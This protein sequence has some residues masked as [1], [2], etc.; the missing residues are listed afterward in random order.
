MQEDDRKT[1]EKKKQNASLPSVSSLEEQSR[2][3][4]VVS[5]WSNLLYVALIV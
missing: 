5:A 3:M 2:M 4:C 1:L